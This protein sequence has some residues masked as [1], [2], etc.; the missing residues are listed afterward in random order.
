MYGRQYF[1]IL[2]ISVAH[3]RD[4]SKFPDEFLL[5]FA[6]SSYQIEG[7]WDEDGKHFEKFSNFLISKNNY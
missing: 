1:I 2:L 3:A 5:G 4:A 7:A 6:T